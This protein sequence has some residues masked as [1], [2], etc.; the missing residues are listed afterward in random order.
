MLLGL[1]SGPVWIIGCDSNTL[2]AEVTLGSTPVKSFITTEQLI[3]SSCE[4]ETALKC[5]T[6][7]S[8]GDFGNA[9]YNPFIT[10]E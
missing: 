5:W 3:M 10:N 7:P 4:G 6:I 2:F 8:D 9:H 1:N